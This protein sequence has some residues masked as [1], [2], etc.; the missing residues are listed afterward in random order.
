MTAAAQAEDDDELLAEVVEKSAVG[1]VA[2]VSERLLLFAV[3][4]AV[5]GVSGAAAYGFLSVFIRGETI[6][7][8]LV[9]GIGDGYTRIVP[10]VSS[11][12]QQTLMSAGTV[13]YVCIWIVVAMPVIMFRDRLVELTLLQPRH[14]AVVVIFAV[15]LLPFLLLRDLR[16][17]FRALRRI[18]L[19]MLV[20]RVFA[21]LA[22]LVGVLAI[23]VGGITSSLL[24]LWVG[25]VGAVVLLVAIGTWL[26][27]RFTD[28]RFGS[29]GS[30]RGV[31]QRFLTYAASTT[32]VAV[33][34][35]VQRRAVFVVMSVYLSPVVAGAFSLSVV[36]ALTVRW[37]LSGVNGI[38]PPI[39]ASLYS[40]GDT[41]RLHRLYQQTSRLAIVVTTPVFV[42]G[43]TYAPELL[44]VISDAYAQQA[45][46]LRVV[47]G[48]QYVATIFG[49]VG[50]LLLM[51]DNE[52][53]SLLTQVFNAAVA[54]P[55]MVTFTTGYGAIGLGVAY[56]L[57]VVLNNTTE[58]AVL[59][60]RDGLTPFSR[61]QVYAIA[62][63]CPAV[64]ACQVI[65][66]IAGIRVSLVFVSLAIA[67]YLWFG[68]R[69]LL[70][71]VDTRAMRAL[72]AE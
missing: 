51:T 63:S 14:E 21:P 20:S 50:L 28:I 41:Q 19:A 56:L 69:V 59:Y 24:N 66:S 27:F 53:A 31:V 60:F 55:L 6:S 47:L 5:A 72:I 61:Q 12:A 15:G 33:L 37:P 11:S 71:S 18:R 1:I 43:Y 34:E 22:L 13:G 57:S 58:L 44:G 62:L 46:V 7:R 67:V 68:K 40:D 8:N 64:Y 45:A 17:M 29:L 48:A 9:A 70:R 39:A 65:K 30:H 25:I 16:D 3:A 10:N 2:F 23:S 38:L 32:G 49:S 42:V 26:L 35:L 52:R 54:L 4:Y 36:V